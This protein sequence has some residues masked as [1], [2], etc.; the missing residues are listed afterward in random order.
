MELDGIGQFS[1]TVYIHEKIIT[2]NVKRVHPS[3]NKFSCAGKCARVSNCD[4]YVHAGSACYPAAGSG[5]K[6]AYTYT[7]AK[8]VMVNKLTTDSAG[9]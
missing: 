1:S 5:L 3:R 2:V 8:R 6:T 9:K 4:A 7:A